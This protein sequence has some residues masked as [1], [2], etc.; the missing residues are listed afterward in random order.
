[1]AIIKNELHLVHCI[2]MGWNFHRTLWKRLDF[3][4]EWED[5]EA[6]VMF[7]H[8]TSKKI[9]KKLTFGPD[10]IFTLFELFPLSWISIKP[11]SKCKPI[12]LPIEVKFIVKWD[13]QLNWD[14]IKKWCPRMWS[15]FVHNRGHLTSSTYVDNHWPH[16]WTST[17][18]DNHC[19]HSWTSTFVDTFCP[20]SWTS[21]YVASKIFNFPTVLWAEL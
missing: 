5:W 12:K 20:H 19:P 10:F 16:S 7:V 17:Y 18:V 13:Q 14:D 1:M 11:V 8:K 15:W 6:A 4:Y 3:I 2:Q 21:T 9:A